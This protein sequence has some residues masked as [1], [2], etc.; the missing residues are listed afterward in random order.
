MR[1]IVTGTLTL[2]L[3]G[4]CS[5]GHARPLTSGTELVYQ[6]DPG[7]PELLGPVRGI[8]TSR[9]EFDG[10]REFWVETRDPDRVVVQVPGT[11][12]SVENGFLRKLIEGT[13][14]L[15]LALVAKDEVQT[16][17]RIGVIR[18][19]E[20]RYDEAVREIAGRADRGAPAPPHPVEPKYI[21]R[22]FVERDDGSDGPRYRE[23][24][25]RWGNLLTVLENDAGFWVDG[26]YLTRASEIVDANGLP[27][28]AFGFNQDGAARLA[29]L[30]GANVGRNLA[31][32]FEGQIR[33]MARI[34]SRL[35]DTAQLTGHFSPD[36]VRA[37]VSILRGGSLP[38]KLNLL[39]KTAIG[40]PAGR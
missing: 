2:A 14:D 5:G 12:E 17:E 27:A 1:A 37:M 16:P 8:L 9:L 36:E 24:K 40:K 39:S 28:L 10:V 23:V 29:A 34:A 25:N 19:E 38:A 18:E 13:G 33:Q 7:R 15:R 4:G 22:P 11:P 32:V 6:I 30:S 31:I 20:R 3:L 26:S 35:Y 21:A